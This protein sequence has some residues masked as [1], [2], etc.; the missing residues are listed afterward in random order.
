MFYS[1]IG[2]EHKN[3]LDRFFIHQIN[4]PNS[5]SYLSKVLLQKR[6]MDHA[7]EK[8]KELRKNGQILKMMGT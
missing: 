3:M 2:S 5:R 4:T 1:Y 8:K 7:K 6:G